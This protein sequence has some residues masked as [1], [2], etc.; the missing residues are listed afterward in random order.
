MLSWK[1]GK[2]EKK[3]PI[4]ILLRKQLLGDFGGNLCRL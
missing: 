4:G 1:H 3:V 2:V